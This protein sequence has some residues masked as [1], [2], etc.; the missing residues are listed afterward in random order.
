[1]LD[2]TESHSLDPLAISPSAIY[3]SIDGLIDLKTDELTGWD[4]NYLHSVG[5][6][7]E[8]KFP[9]RIYLQ[10]DFSVEWSRFGEGGTF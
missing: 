7:A 1:M 2:R 9:N 8:N 6:G 10:L 4:P 5:I 3:L